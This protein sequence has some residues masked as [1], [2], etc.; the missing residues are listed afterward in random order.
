MSRRLV[1]AGIV[2]ALV[3][4]AE[5]TRWDPEPA[6]RP[7]ANVPSVHVVQR[8]DT[9]YQIAFRHR[10]D[11][12]DLAA[13]NRLGDA[14]RIFPGQHIRLSPPPGPARGDAARP[15]SRPGPAASR[16]APPAAA[17]AATAPARSRAGPAPE[18]RWPVDGPLLWRFGESRRNPT[19]I[20]IGGQDGW[21]I[22]AAS[23][24][25]VVYSGSGLIGYGQLIIL[26]HN[27]SYLSAYG[28]NRALRVAE[29]DQVKSGQVI[30]L[31]GRG[32]ADRP[33]LH[34]EIRVDGRPADPAR[35]LPS[36]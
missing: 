31:M 14:G 26:K 11:W 33:L 17:P 24:G 34:F 19:G 30:A 10:L 8:G 15:A 1:L 29:G 18:W 28:Y 21:E 5:L 13:W 25:Q 3:G 32:P 22:R 7:A 2:L 9:L 16:P 23:D 12:R 36:R 27:D 20:G 4:C 35:F 6:S